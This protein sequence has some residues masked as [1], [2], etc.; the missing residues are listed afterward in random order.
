MPPIFNDVAKVILITPVLPRDAVLGDV[1]P[2]IM[3]GQTAIRL[4]DDATS[5][6]ARLARSL[7]PTKGSLRG[8]PAELSAMTRFVASAPC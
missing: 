7:S 5:L 2:H 6:R 3:L 1:P 4:A 8:T